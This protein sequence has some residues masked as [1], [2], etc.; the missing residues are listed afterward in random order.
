VNTQKSNSIQECSSFMIFQSLYYGVES[1]K[2]AIW[3]NRSYVLFEN[4]SRHL[5]TI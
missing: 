5:Y 3:W 1:W 4:Y 2:M